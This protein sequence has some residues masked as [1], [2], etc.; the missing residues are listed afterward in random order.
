MGDAMLEG[1]IRACGAAVHVCG[2]S[3]MDFDK[4]IDNVRYVQ[5]ALGYPND[6]SRARDGGPLVLARSGDAAG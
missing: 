3:H 1:Q 2:H 6:F 4:T 5:R